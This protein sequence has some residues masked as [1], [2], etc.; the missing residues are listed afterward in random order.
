M[1]FI[2][3][4]AALI[5]LV[6]FFLPANGP[7]ADT[8]LT[9]KN[10]FNSTLLQPVREET[11]ADSPVT[12]LTV[13]LKSA[14]P[15]KASQSLTT[16]FPAGKYIADSR[17]NT[18]QIQCP[19]KDK[20]RILAFL[21]EIDVPVE[22][23]RVKVE[24]IEVNYEK[25]DDFRHL[26]SGLSD[27]FKINYDLSTGQ[28]ISPE[29]F[30]ALLLNLVKTGRASIKSRP[31]IST[32]DNTKATI[33]IGDKVPYTTTVF[34]NQTTITQVQYLDTGISLDIHPRITSGN[35]ITAGLSAQVSNVKLWHQAGDSRYPVLASR[36]AE[37]T[38]T[39][40]DGETLV[41]AG[42]MGE[43]LRSN[44]T[45]IP[46]LSDIPLIGDLFKSEQTETQTSDI[47]LLITPEI[48]K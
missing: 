4:V 10:S 45:G 22:Q 23:V 17:T 12:M 32:L 21:N 24:V 28:L 37:T 40:K 20:E 27:G 19:E 42:L 46:V 29:P 6:F 36:S 3:R 41:I 7:Y 25:T 1:R 34:Q 13:K 35:H 16:F 31:E 5:G 2:P 33:R 38:V 14:P 8:I 26:L 11:S 39:I 30:Q 9:Y 43:H 15:E 44:R 18:L 47:V 48:I